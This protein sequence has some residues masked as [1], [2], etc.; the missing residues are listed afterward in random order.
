MT[1]AVLAAADYYPD[2]LA[3]SVLAYQLDAPILLVGSSE[4]D[5]EKVVDY[6]KANLEQE[7][8]VYILG[9]TAVVNSGMDAEIQ[10]SGFN[11]ITRI[12]GETR[13]DTAVKIADQLNVKTGTPV[14]LVSGENY[15]DALAVSSIAAQNQFPF[16]LVQKDGINDAVS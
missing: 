11:H 10:N 6:L 5:Q 12:A 13:Y 8:T 2:A 15:P 14:V 4:A 16:L 3:G 1:N 7:G 9:G